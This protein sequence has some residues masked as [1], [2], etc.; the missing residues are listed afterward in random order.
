MSN[1]AD[2]LVR[3]LN[4]WDPKSKYILDNGLIG[5]YRDGNSV[6]YRVDEVGA[7]LWLLD[8]VKNRTN[9]HGQGV[10]EESLNMVKGCM[11]YLMSYESRP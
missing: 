11:Q 7:T 9:Q 4:V 8:L 2:T 1:T 5:G 3:L 6:L 10:I